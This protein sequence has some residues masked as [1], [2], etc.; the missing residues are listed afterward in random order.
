MTDNLEWSTQWHLFT[1]CSKYISFG[2]TTCQYHVSNLFHYSCH[3][4]RNQW[5]TRNVRQR[6]APQC[7]KCKQPMKGHK[8]GQC[9]T[10]SA[11]QPWKGN[12]QFFQPN[13]IFQALRLI[14]QAQWWLHIN[15]VKCSIYEMVANLLIG[16]VSVI[17]RFL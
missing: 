9:S 1:W 17:L 14:M 4:N 11:T 7:K 13:T 15:T 2:L 3:I 12:S 10:R 5:V 6:K 16:Y 8:K